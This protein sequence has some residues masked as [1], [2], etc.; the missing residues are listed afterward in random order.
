MIVDSVQITG[1]SA[2]KTLFVTT[3]IIGTQVDVAS[4][5]GTLLVG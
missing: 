1:I 5:L 4:A 3:I 2:L